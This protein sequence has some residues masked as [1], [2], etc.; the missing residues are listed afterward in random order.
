MAN[1]P[2]EPAL[3]YSP[4][5][6]L[7]GWE[8][9]DRQRHAEK[10]KAENLRRQIAE[11]DDYL[12]E[13][14]ARRRKSDAEFEKADTDVALAP[15]DRKTKRSKL[16]QEEQS[17]IT[18]KAGEILKN[19][20]MLIDQMGDDP[21]S[22]E[23]AWRTDPE[24]MKR[25]YGTPKNSAN[26]KIRAAV[27][28]RKAQALRGIGE[29]KAGVKGA[30]VITPDGQVKSEIIDPVT[31]ESSP[32]GKSTPGMEVAKLGRKGT[33]SGMDKETVYDTTKDLVKEKQLNE[34]SATS[35]VAD[36]TRGNYT[37][38]RSGDEAKFQK[39]ITASTYDLTRRAQAVVNQ[40]R[41]MER[42][43]PPQLK[44]TLTSLRTRLSA[45]ANG[46][47]KIAGDALELAKRLR[48][49]DQDGWK[50][51]VDLGASDKHYLDDTEVL[52]R[53]AEIQAL[54]DKGDTDKA[55]KLSNGL[56]PQEYID[57]PLHV[58]F[59]YKAE[60]ERL[61]IK[62]PN[63]DYTTPSDKIEEASKVQQPTS[64]KAKSG[65]FSDTFL[66]DTEAA[67][68]SKVGKGLPEE[69]KKA[70]VAEALGTLRTINEAISIIKKKNPQA[71]KGKS[72]AQILQEMMQRKTASK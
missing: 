61:G 11:N 15:Q 26:P 18:D 6:F 56:T 7:A 50:D 27:A 13:Q 52:E 21:R 49:V 17:F 10:V 25:L 2:Y 66:K 38:V 69:Q 32:A 29:R 71:F 31:L 63:P 40:L 19:D 36:K 5:G 54:L 35:I 23:A 47:V 46:E 72:E 57:T 30:T 24:R 53:K 1:N 60:V 62:I 59:P 16:E 48:V 64:V 55:A 20:M 14:R 8:W 39:D 33:G 67:I 58:Q 43:A 37:F 70:Q 3:N 34:L 9:Q 12:Y 51:W 28:A 45:T 65:G 42:R 44:E 68:R 4:E 22:I 41:Q